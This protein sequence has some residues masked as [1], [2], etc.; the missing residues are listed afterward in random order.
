MRMFAPMRSQPLHLGVQQPSCTLAAPFPE[1]PEHHSGR[2]LPR[3]QQS[4][5]VLQPLAGKGFHRMLACARV[6]SISAHTARIP[7]RASLSQARAGQARRNSYAGT[8]LF[9]SPTHPLSS[10]RGSSVCSSI[11]TVPRCG[12]AEQL[13][14]RRGDKPFDPDPTLL[15]CVPWLP[16]G[17]EATPFRR[18]RRPTPSMP[19]SWTSTP[20]FGIAAFSSPWA[21]TYSGSPRS[22]QTV[23]RRRVVVIRQWVFLVGKDGSGP[24]GLHFGSFRD[25]PSGQ[26]RQVCT[27]VLKRA[28]ERPKEIISQ[29]MTRRISICLPTH[30]PSTHTKAQLSG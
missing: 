27:S 29:L 3:Y 1:H 16:V 7:M 13:G 6:C 20:C 28:A 4:R 12:A 2:I 22:P 24:V 8:L 15:P 17:N 26:N 25:A 23:Q 14:Y 30:S 9:R 11:S 5:P 10:T 18:T 19:S 21:I